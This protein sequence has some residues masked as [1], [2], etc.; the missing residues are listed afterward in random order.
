MI[1]AY[2]KYIYQSKIYFIENLIYFNDNDGM[3]TKK[4]RENPT[5]NLK[6]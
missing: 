4:Y 5:L 1:C 6:T 2:Y 3:D